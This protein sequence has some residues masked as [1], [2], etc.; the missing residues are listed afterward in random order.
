MVSDTTLQIIGLGNLW[1]CARVDEWNSFE[2]CQAPKGASWVRIPPLPLYH[3]S[4]WNL[5]MNKQQRKINTISQ[6]LGLLTKKDKFTFG[7]YGNKTVKTVLDKD[8]SYI[9][10]VHDNTSHKFS[11]SVISEAR[12]LSAI[13]RGVSTIDEDSPSLYDEIQQLGDIYQWM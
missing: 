9:C 3:V 12:E 8:P 10:W 4:N 7:K 1:K 11:S 5:A 2:N 6:G 13:N